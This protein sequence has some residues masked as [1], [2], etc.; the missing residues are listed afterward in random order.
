MPDLQQT[1]APCVS[2][3]IPCLNEEKT[4]VRCIE[5]AQEGM[6]RAAISGEI[7]VSDNGSTDASVAIAEKAGARVVHCVDRGYGN[8]LRAG[9]AAARGEWI[10][11]GDGDLSYDFR[12]LPRFLEEI[13]KGRDLVMGTRLRG[14][15]EP[16]AMPWLNRHFGNPLLSALI[17]LFFGSRVSD[18]NCGLRAFRRAAL[19]K[20]NL[21]TGGMEMAG[22]IVIKAAVAGLNTTEIPITLHPD[23]RGRPPHMRP[24]RDGWRNLRYILMMA[25]NW[26]FILPGGILFALGLSLV[27]AAP[28]VF[29]G[30]PATFDIYAMVLGM[31]LVLVGIYMMLMGVLVKVFTYAERLGAGGAPFT[32]ALA[33][34]KLEHGL[35]AA[36]VLIVAGLAG[37]A[38]ILWLW[39]EGLSPDLAD[40]N[41]IRAFILYTASLIAGVE[42]FSASFFISMLGITRDDY[43]GM[44]DFTR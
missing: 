3:V 43:V 42:V 9:F 16:G 32:R 37:D 7:I 8:A 27:I 21:H 23:G 19:P 10:L 31:S 25:P 1:D 14:V 15:V 35:I 22:E 4:L 44:H 40:H 30:G 12:E 5:A 33:S 39:R 24:F 2:V 17:R 6:R 38:R 28:A 34:V 26:L 18:V 36:A 20:M 13:R 41:L 11:M 29:R